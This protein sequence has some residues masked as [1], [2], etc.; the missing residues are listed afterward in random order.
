MMQMAQAQIAWQAAA[1]K[2]KK[3]RNKGKKY[4]N[5]D[6]SSSSSSSFSSSSLFPVV[7]APA[8]PAASTFLALEIN[9]QPFALEPDMDSES[10]RTALLDSGLAR[11]KGRNPA[12]V[13]VC[14][15]VGSLMS[16]GC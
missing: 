6:L 1:G 8:L 5:I 13:C 15:C 4:A 3:K 7:P 9:P 11:R 10:V 14:V 16:V 12:K 2:P